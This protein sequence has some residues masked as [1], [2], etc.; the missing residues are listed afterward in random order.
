M[1]GVQ[2]II[3]L[4]KAWQQETGQNLPL[5]MQRQ[6]LWG[7]WAVAIRP[8]CDPGQPLANAVRALVRYRRKKYKEARHICVST[9]AFRYFVGNTD[10]AQEDLAEAKAAQRERAGK[11]K[12]GLAAVCQATG[13]PIPSESV[14]ES[15]PARPAGEILACIAEMKALVA[16]A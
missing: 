16:A 4:H 14:K 1:N 13:R 11:S 8:M 7:Q 5:D 9:L 15:R 3:D 2:E 10:Y 12:P 6:N